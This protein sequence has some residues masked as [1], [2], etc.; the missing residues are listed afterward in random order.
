MRVLGLAFLLL[1]SVARA[2]LA[3]NPLA[4]ASSPTFTG[5]VTFTTDPQVQGSLAHH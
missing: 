5:V 4:A 2:Q 1:A 3:G